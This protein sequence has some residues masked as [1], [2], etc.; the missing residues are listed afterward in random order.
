MK[1]EK[2]SKK[3]IKT[4]LKIIGIVLL[5]LV[6]IVAGY[7][8][9][10]LAAYHRIGDQTL[11]AGRNTEAVC[12]PGIEY[13]ILSYNI[14]FGAYE[15]DYGFF[16][17]G[18]KQSRAWSKTRLDKNLNNIAAFLKEQ[19]ADFYIVQEVDIGSTR[20]YQV[21][22]RTYLSDAL[23]D[24]AYTFAQNYD[25]PYLFYP[26]FSP[27]GAS[28][29]GLMTFSFAGIS[30]AERVE[31]PVEK[32]L[33]KFLDLDRCYSK[34]YIPAD[35]GR[36]LVLYN[37]HLSAYTSDGKIATEQL[38]LI[39]DDMDAEFAKG[40]YCIAGGDFNKDLLGDSSEYFGK[41]DKEYTWAQPIPEGTFD[42]HNVTLVAPFDESAPVPSCRNADGPYHKGQFVLTVDGFMVTDNVEVLYADVIDI[43]F[44]YSDHNPV[45]MTFRLN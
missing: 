29:S 33:T 35:N 26:I 15:P 16:M 22:Q 28:R 44:A 25:S 32:G 38:K 30:A 21:D 3:G 5:C 27:H 34:N 40:N 42:D 8:I 7:V 13:D 31:L 19:A 43:G 18:G 4:A 14:G 37:F 20:S 11:K 23:P 24:M 6:L 12:A 39:L 17:D 41:A 2:N 10:L 1:K 45:K 9:Y 36:S